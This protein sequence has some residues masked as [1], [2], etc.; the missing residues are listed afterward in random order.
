MLTE[1]DSGDMIVPEGTQ[2]SLDIQFNKAIATAGW[3]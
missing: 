3:N 2:V 1:E